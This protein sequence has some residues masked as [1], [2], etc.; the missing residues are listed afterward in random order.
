M[1]DEEKTKK[2]RE[3]DPVLAAIL[4]DDMYGRLKSIPRHVHSNTY[5]HSVHTAYLAGKLADR[6]G[7]DRIQ[8]ERAGLLHDFCFLDSSGP[9]PIRM[10]YLHCHPRFAAR[11]SERFG[12]TR[13]EKD[14][15]RNH[16]WPLSGKRPSTRL[17]WCINLA[18]KAAAITEFFTF[19]G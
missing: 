13:E 2:L 12:T 8:A 15:I 18:D 1:K 6:L 11:M 10:K 16:M 5:D 3:D 7:A 9:I 4:N 14:A 17:A 19:W